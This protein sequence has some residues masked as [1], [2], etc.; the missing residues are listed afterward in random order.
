MNRC[1]LEFIG[2]RR[3]ERRSERTLLE[4]LA[5]RPLRLAELLD[6]AGPALLDPA[7]PRALAMI[8]DS[9]RARLS[10]T[11]LDRFVAWAEARFGTAFCRRAG[12]PVGR[13]TLRLAS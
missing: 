8:L 1:P 12:L 11:Q 13:P 4:Q 6:T 7:S 10:R 9:Y 5:E 2:D 3:V